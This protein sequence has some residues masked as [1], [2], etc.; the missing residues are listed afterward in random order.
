MGSAVCR[1]F[2]FMLL[3]LQ[4][5]SQPVFNVQPIES[6]KKPCKE[7]KYCICLQFMTVFEG[8]YKYMRLHCILLAEQTLSSAG[9][10]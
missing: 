1:D 2:T 9:Y 10:V 5:L 3:Q 8:L 4:L 6:S 7:I